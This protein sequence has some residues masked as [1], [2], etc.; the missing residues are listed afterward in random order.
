MLLALITLGLFVSVIQT[1]SQKINQS[2]PGYLTF[3]NGVVGAFYVSDWVGPKNGMTYHHIPETTPANDQTFTKRDFFQI[4]M[5]PAVSGLLFF[6]LGLMIFFYLPGAGRYPLLLLHFFAGNYLILCPDFHL[7][8]QFN[9]LLLTCFVFLPATVIHFALL[10]PEPSQRAKKNPWL[11]YL[12]YKIS[13]FILL[14]YMYF[15]Y[16]PKVWIKVE[17]VAFA[18]LVFSYLFWIAELFRTLKKP[19][20]EFNRIISKYLLLGQ[21]IAFS[22]PLFAALAIYF[23]SYSF[24]L[25]LATPLSLLFPISVFMGVILGRLRQ[26]QVQLIQSEK[27]AALGN[28]LAGLAHEI[29]NPM[30]FVYSSMEPLKEMVQELKSKPNPETWSNVDQLLAVIE[31]GATRS[32]DIIESFRYFSHPD[33]K[34]NQNVDIHAVIDQSLQLLKPKWKDRIEIQ[35]H[36]GALPIYQGQTT[37]LGQIFVNLISNACYAIKDRG[38]IEIVT[39][40]FR[41]RIVISIKDNGVGI[42]KETMSKIFDAFYTTREQGQGTGLGLS[43]VLGIVKKYGGTLDVKSENNKGSEF[44]ISLPVNT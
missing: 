19:Q 7:T 12:P 31:E 42:P 11:Y 18:Y 37:E 40:M 27:N 9:Y 1:S 35:K 28:L 21:I 13:L 32:K 15:F 41:D 38:K 5:L 2:F 4:A 33:Q 26:S 16:Q 10:F 23:T 20:L 24:P 34:E 22:I 6:L 25:N 17:A 30:T 29:N 8:Y 39:G 14:P 43:I 44:I 36:Y 3:E